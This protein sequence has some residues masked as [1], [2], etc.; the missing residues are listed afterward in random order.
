MSD[1]L[2]KLG[3]DWKLFI[4]QLVNFLILFLVLRFFAWK[5]LVNALEERRAKIRQGV[6]DANKAETRLKEIEC[7]RGDVLAQARQE[8]AKIIEQAE[9]KAQTLKEEKMRLA[10]NEIEQQVNEAK[11]V[12][13]A[14]R[15]EAYATLKQEA[16]R[17]IAA[18]TG[19]IVG[20][21][22]DKSQK[23]LI[24]DAIAELEAGK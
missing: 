17:L 6:D 11:D 13:K 20:E 5:A 2:T 10:K 24:D 19:K 15:A 3:I 12:I 14:E 7:E 23:K 16:G 8:A 1:M 4:A 9:A 22:D 18:A 21:L